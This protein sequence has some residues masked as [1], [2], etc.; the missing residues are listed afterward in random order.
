M[1]CS[2]SA[3]GLESQGKEMVV[4]EPVNLKE[5]VVYFSEEEW[6]LLDPSQRALYWDVMQENY[7]AVSW[8][9]CRTPMS[10]PSSAHGQQSQGK[11][12]AVAEPV[13]FEEVAVY[14]SEEEWA[15]LDPGQRALYWDVMQENYEAVSWL[16]K[17]SCSLG[18]QRWVN[19]GAAGLDL[20]QG[21]SMPHALLCQ[22]NPPQ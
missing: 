9:G 6:A 15:L 10:C 13:S 14:F 17:D 1:S 16:G 2:S 20:V 11:E 5:V 19:S 3:H 22:E 12:V 18:Y 7:E 8:L 21:S 4:V